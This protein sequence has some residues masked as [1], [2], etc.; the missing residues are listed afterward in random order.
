MGLENIQLNQVETVIKNL[1]LPRLFAAE[2]R[3]GSLE[4]P[5]AGAIEAILAQEYVEEAVPSGILKVI[6]LVCFYDILYYLEPIVYGLVLSTYGSLKLAVS[7]FSTTPF[8]ISLSSRP[9]SHDEEDLIREEARNTVK[10]NVGT[11]ALAVGFPAQILAVTGIAG[12]NLVPFDLAPPQL[13][14]WVVVLILIWIGPKIPS[15]SRW[16]LKRNG[17]LDRTR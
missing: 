9:S 14:A 6:L 12:V 13:P 17:M 7:G 15:V 10:S 16:F 11:V 8:G 1:I 5:D 2:D 3:Y 4:G